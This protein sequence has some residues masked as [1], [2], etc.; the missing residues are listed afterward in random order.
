MEQLVDT[1]W[2]T[3]PPHTARGQIQVI[4]SALRK[5]LA[6][7]DLTIRTQPP[8]YLL[9]VPSG[10]LDTEMFSQLVTS[11]RTHAAAQRYV[12]AAGDLHAAL[13]LWRG[14]ALAGLPGNSMRHEAALLEDRRLAAYEER[15]RLDLLLGRHQDIIGELR[16]LVTDH[17][18]RE[19]FH[20]FLMLS[21]YRSGRQAE[22]LE[23]WRRARAVLVA[24]VGVE[25]G[26]ELQDMAN[27]ILNRDSSL[28]LPRSPAPDGAGRTGVAEQPVPHQLPA[29]IADFVG[30]EDSLNEIKQMLGR[31]RP[32]ES[33]YAVRI[34]AVSGRG[35]VGKSCL[36]IRAA[37]ELSSAFPDGQLY[38]D[39]RSSG[40]GGT[41]KVLTHFLRSLGVSGTAIPDD[42]P[43]RVRLYRSLLAGKRI[44]IMLDDVSSEADVRPLIPG[45]PSCAVVITSRCRLSSLP[46][47]HWIDVDP[48][49]SGQ[50]VELLG[51][52]IG[53]ERLRAELDMARELADLCEGLP[54]ALRIAGARLASRQ[55]WRLADLVRRLRDATRVLDELAHGGLELRSNI[56]LTYSG[57]TTPVQRLFRLVG[58]VTAPDFPAWVAAA[59]LDTSVADAENLI[60]C[61]VD[62]RVLDVVQFPTEGVLRYRFHDLV[63]V[64]ARERLMETESRADR[65]AAL[66]RYLGGWLSLVEEA[67]RR[68]YGGDFTILHGGAPR[69]RPPDG[70]WSCVDDPMHLLDSGQRG[71]MA[72]IGQAAGEDMDELCWDLALTSV[73]LF[74]AKGYL[75]EW[76]ESARTAYVLAQRTGSRRGQAAMLYS[77]GTLH[78]SRKYLA[79]AERCLSLALTEFEALGDSLGCALVLRNAAHVEWLRGN[80]AAAADKYDQSLR[81]SRAVGDPIAEAHILCGMA[82]IRIVERDFA[83]ATGMLAEALAI[84]QEKRCTRVEA[85]V[86]YRFAELYLAT[87]DLESAR[88]ALN[89]TL[90]MVRSMGDR[91]GEAYT[92]Y[93]LGVVRHL[94][95]RLD[96]ADTT[97]RHSLALATKLGERWVA[98]QSCYALGEVALTRGDASTG[99]ARLV[100]AERLFNAL[101][102]ALWHGRT[103]VVLSEVHTTLGDIVVGRGE[104]R[105]AEQLLGTVDSAE[106]AR[107]IARLR[108]TQATLLAG[109]TAG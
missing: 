50:S 23:V 30:R 105:Q 28:D 27:A 29:S 4:I 62:A 40:A 20:S 33:A 100:E 2:D 18:L 8:G 49:D 75:D 80:A 47:A 21:L 109:G 39:A 108:K 31:T 48:L 46:G 41:G 54:L 1:I 24:E 11:A 71:L 69:W 86:M 98:A 106:S 61:L 16:G 95:G 96:N 7:T 90:R 67:H 59:L 5:V 64:Y 68:E 103:L 25:P 37:Q 56:G 104:T 84:C 107:W 32:P 99:L 36:A 12:E 82:R 10:Q 89:R 34:V 22:A 72:A 88:K 55:H 35:G 60:E 81:R 19:R 58:L 63:N 51:K 87:D 52:I 9:D 43:D 38:A 65:R 14:P 53:Q 73:T 92:L 3:H 66:E 44:L 6:G 85:Q 15:I 78:L 93:S 70:G 26:H 57:L 17:P 97:L 42:Q 83:T 91:I 79:A 74:E 76:Q 13:D 94:E 45:D 102:S 77:L 101:G